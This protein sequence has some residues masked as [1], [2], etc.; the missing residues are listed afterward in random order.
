MTKAEL[1]EFMRAQHHAVE[2]SIS[3]AG[4]P[5]A[6]VVGIVVTDRFELFFDTLGDTRK[7]QNLRHRPAAAFVIGGPEQGAM[8]TVQ[9][10]GVADEPEGPEL[11]RLKTLY[12]SRFPEG[13]ARQSWPGLTYFRV[14]PTWIRYSDFRVEPPLI[15]EWSA[16]QLVA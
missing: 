5:Q 6:A 3:T 4:G 12:L 16:G 11:L 8:R 2:A 14:R 9:Y 1:L 7:A 13:I 10:E 15:V